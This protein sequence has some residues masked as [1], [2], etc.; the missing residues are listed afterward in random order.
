MSSGKSTDCGKLKVL[1]V[2]QYFWPE[3]FRINELVA[4]LTKR[5]HEVTV[6]TGR[7]NYPEGALYPEYLKNPSA[8]ELYEGAEIVRVPLVPRGNRKLQLLINYMSFPIS[9]CLLGAW[10]LRGRQFDVVLSIGLSPIFANV[11]AVIM[12]WLKAAPHVLW[13]LDL[14]PDTL[15]AVGIIQS[16][17]ILALVGKVVAWVY[18]R[19][20]LILAQSKSF[21]DQI[22]KYAPSDT[23]IE[24]FPAWADEIFQDMALN[25]FAPEVPFQPETFTVL[26]AGNIGEAQDFPAILAAAEQVRQ[27][28]DIRW[29]I[30][31]DGR[32]SA[33]V[34][35]EAKRRGLEQSVLIVGRHPLAR[36]PEFFAHADA[37]LISLKD[38]QLFS[39][40]IP[41]KLQSYF[42]SGLPILAMLNG[43]G[44][45]IVREAAAGLA[46][47][48]GDSAA[49]ARIVA[50][51]ADS[52]DDV[53]SQFGRNARAYCATNFNKKI[54][55]DQLEQWMSNLAR[56]KHGSN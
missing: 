48:A 28:T 14:W 11:P 25:Q 33:W 38:E 43:E 2:S 49:L 52:D 10:K 44:A 16:E 51:L 39:M 7:P 6:L 37:L 47:D 45:K 26:F 23:R 40:T 54:L 31:G 41:G 20:D 15:K 53:R 17:K 30:V 50:Q 24:Y 3:N 27:R 55:I 1:L 21:E 42:A 8:F 22:E 9:A 34:A 4:E 36:M 19:S 5:G 56:I 12:R 18:R 29:V 46:C 35:K 32:E 13:I